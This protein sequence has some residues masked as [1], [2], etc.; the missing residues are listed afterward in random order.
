[1]KKNEKKIQIA[2]L[3]S[4]FML[5]LLTYF[6]YPYMNKDKPAKDQSAQDN[7]EKTLTDDQFTTFESLKYEGLY[8]LNKTFTIKSEKAYILDDEPDIVYMTNMH[9]ILH[10]KNERI[11][12]IISDKGRYNKVTHD[13][14]FEENVEATDGETKIFA[15]NIDMLSTKNFVKVYN[16]VKLN[17][18]MGVLFSDKIDYDFETKYFKVSMFDDKTVKMK[19]IK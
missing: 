13:C 12:N 5:I 2:L 11:V 18:P 3:I 16:N 7:L 14:F 8:D 15:Q 1:M 19:V 17:H 6:Y 9:V 4:G 10:L